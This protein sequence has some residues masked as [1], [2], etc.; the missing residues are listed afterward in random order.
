MNTIA[1]PERATDPWRPFGPT[2][3]PIATHPRDTIAPV[4]PPRFPA[5]ATVAWANGWTSLSP[6]APP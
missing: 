5:I 3:C 6:T 1:G 4:Y 2:D